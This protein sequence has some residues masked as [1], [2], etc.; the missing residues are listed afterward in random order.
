[1]NIIVDHYGTIVNADDIDVVKAMVSNKNIP[2]CW[3]VVL[4]L[5]HHSHLTL[6]AE[7]STLEEG[8]LT[9]DE[10]VLIVDTL[11]Q[12]FSNGTI[13]DDRYPTKEFIAKGIRII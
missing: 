11:A 3:Y 12:W 2:N 9:K 10:A 6:I 7:N 4:M 13:G 5:K 8:G 1:M